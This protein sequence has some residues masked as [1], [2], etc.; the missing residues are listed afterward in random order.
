MG[1]QGAQG[2]P[3]GPQAASWGASRL[4]GQARLQTWGRAARLEDVPPGRFSQPLFRN[5]LV[6]VTFR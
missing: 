2:L 5:Q 6:E 3:R 1:L 4:E